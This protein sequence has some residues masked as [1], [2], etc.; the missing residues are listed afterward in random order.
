[1][2]LRGQSKTVFGNTRPKR[3]DSPKRPDLLRAQP[4]FEKSGTIDPRY[5]DQAQAIAVN[6]QLTLPV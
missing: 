6:K 4:M 3:P 2:A 5:S 1:M